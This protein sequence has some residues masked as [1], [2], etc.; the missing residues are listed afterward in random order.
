MKSPWHH[1]L[2][3]LAHCQLQAKVLS[4]AER[5]I[6]LKIR[7][8]ILLPPFHSRRPKHTRHIHKRL[9]RHQLP[10][11]ALLPHLLALRHLPLSND[12]AFDSRIPHLNLN[13]QAR[14]LAATDVYGRDCIIEGKAAGY[15]GAATY[16]CEMDVRGKTGGGVEPAEEGIGEDHTC[17][18]DVLEGGEVGERARDEFSG[19]EGLKEAWGYAEVGYSGG[20]L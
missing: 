7:A 11:L 2:S 12:S 10:R 1:T 6:P 15:V 5:H 9:H 3:N 18:G 20:R 13:A 16:V 17:G 14:S 4:S 19:E 8:F